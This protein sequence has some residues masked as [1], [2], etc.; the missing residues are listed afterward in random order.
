MWPVEAG[1]AASCTPCS[2]TSGAASSGARDSGCRGTDRPPLSAQVRRW[3]GRARS[4]S[5]GLKAKV[6]ALA[7]TRASSM[8]PRAPRFIQFSIGS[9]AP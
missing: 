7:R 9:I 3:R 5:C 2:S 8:L 4:R 1:T 6:E